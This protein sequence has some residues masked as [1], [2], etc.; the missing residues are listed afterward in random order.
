MLKALIT[1]WVFTGALRVRVLT[2]RRVFQEAVASV[3][4]DWSAIDGMAEFD[5]NSATFGASGAAVVRGD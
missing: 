2:F 3:R 1:F 4:V 5:H